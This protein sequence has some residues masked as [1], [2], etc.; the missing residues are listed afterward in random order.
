[1]RPGR[2]RI[3]DSPVVSTDRYLRRK[4]A[5]SPVGIHPPPKKN[6]ATAMS[7]GATAL[8]NEALHWFQRALC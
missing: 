1:M 3:T 2:K 4:L 6:L 5:L 7:L 8:C